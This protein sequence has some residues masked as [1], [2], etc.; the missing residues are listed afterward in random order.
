[1]CLKTSQ[2]DDII[3]MIPIIKKKLGKQLNALE[4]M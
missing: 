2:Y 4:Y 1:M 3:K